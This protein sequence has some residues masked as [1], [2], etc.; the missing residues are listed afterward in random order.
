[1]DNRE[2]S[3]S[4]LSELSKRQLDVLL[5]NSIALRSRKE[6][7]FKILRKGADPNI[8][9]PRGETPLYESVPIE[10]IEL[11]NELIKY[12]A[13]IDIP[14]DYFNGPPIVWAAAT[15][16]LEVVETFIKNNADAYIPDIDGNTAMHKAFMN[17]RKDIIY[18]LIELG[19]FGADRKNNMNQEPMDM[20]KSEHFNDKELRELM[21]I[22]IKD[23]NYTPDYNTSYT[24]FK[25]HKNVKESMTVTLPLVAEGK[26]GGKKKYNKSKTKKQS[27]KRKIRKTLQKK[28][29]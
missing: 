18:K 27:K 25:L 8:T 17:G 2:L 24:L 20:A 15:N 21:R 7:I 19:K 9:T 3:D 28:K 13:K 11:I 1:M 14:G 5:Y 22:A 29:K 4:E 16:R 12:G 23:F 26:S 10:D 6:Y